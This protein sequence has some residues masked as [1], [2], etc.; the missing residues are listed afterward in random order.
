MRLGTLCLG[1]CLLFLTLALSACDSSENSPSPSPESASVANTPTDTPYVTSPDQAVGIVLDFLY[2]STMLLPSDDRQVAVDKMLYAEASE[3][4]KALNFP[5]LSI[6]PSNYA[7][8]R[9]AS[10]PPPG[11]AADEP[12]YCITVR[13]DFIDN[14]DVSKP[15]RAGIEICWEGE[16]GA[17]ICGHRVIVNGVP[18]ES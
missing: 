8:P 7:C 9:G 12:G 6:R 2:R 16:P 3:R 14:S 13:A 15:R 1:G 17:S 10:C 18:T 4:G 11:E 5:F